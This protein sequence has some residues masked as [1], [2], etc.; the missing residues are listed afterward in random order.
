MNRSIMHENCVR[1][2]NYVIDIKGRQ[3]EAC[4]KGYPDGDQY[5]PVFEIRD[6]RGEIRVVKEYSAK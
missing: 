6:G 1:G 5:S 4:F 3:F 2:K